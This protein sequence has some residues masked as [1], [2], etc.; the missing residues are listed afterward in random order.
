[1]KVTPDV[2]AWFVLLIASCNGHEAEI[3]RRE[4]NPMFNANINNSDDELLLKIARE[5]R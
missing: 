4:F 2:V 1:M 5:Y 3:N